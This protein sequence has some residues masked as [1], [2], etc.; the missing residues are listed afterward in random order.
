MR[1]LMTDINGAS[2]KIIVNG[3][4]SCCGNKLEEGRLFICEECQKKEDDLCE[5]RRYVQR[6]KY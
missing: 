5:N 2:A 6:D 4:C 1:N 3:R